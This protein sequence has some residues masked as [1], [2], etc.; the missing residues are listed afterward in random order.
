MALEANN[1]IIFKLDIFFKNTEKVVYLSNL[2]HISMF[3]SKKI[4]KR[5]K[6]TPF[7]LQCSN[8]V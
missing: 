6:N 1:V 2:K 7:S 3:E 5:C 4:L 8:S